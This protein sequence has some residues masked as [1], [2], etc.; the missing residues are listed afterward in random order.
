MASEL[1]TAQWVT[2]K[3]L[4]LLHVRGNFVRARHREYQSNLHNGAWFIA[5][6]TTAAKD[7]T[8]KAMLLILTL[9]LAALVFL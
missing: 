9:A 2:R 1:V 3:A 6:A 5:Q 8:Q 4:I 7:A